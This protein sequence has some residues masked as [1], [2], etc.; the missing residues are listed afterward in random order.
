M[1]TERRQRRILEH[2]RIICGAGKSSPETVPI[3]ITICHTIFIW[4]PLVS[5][6]L[7]REEI[8]DLLVNFEKNHFWPTTWIINA[9]KK[10]WGLL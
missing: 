10:V 6:P 7:E 5:D 1:P 3:S 9:L 4:G 8:V 2:S